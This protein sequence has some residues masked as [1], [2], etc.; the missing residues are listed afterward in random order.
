MDAR[1][2]FGVWDWGFDEGPVKLFKETDRRERMGNFE[3]RGKG[4]CY[5]YVLIFLYCRIKLCA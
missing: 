4:A 2:C 5:I 3:K 1:T